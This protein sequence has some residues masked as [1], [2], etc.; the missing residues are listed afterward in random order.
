[1]A[2][3]KLPCNASRSESPARTSMSGVVVSR[4][5]I[6]RATARYLAICVSYRDLSGEEDGLHEPRD[7]VQEWEIKSA[8]VSSRRIDVKRRSFKIA[9]RS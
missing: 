7:A 6:V 4:Y 3:M 5:P 1:M 9:L 2:C 8:A